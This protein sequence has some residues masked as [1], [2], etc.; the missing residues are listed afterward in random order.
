MRETKTKQVQQTRFRT[1][2][3]QM[4]CRPTIRVPVCFQY[5]L[6]ECIKQAIRPSTD[7]SGIN[8][9]RA[10]DQ[11]INRMQW[12]GTF[13]SRFMESKKDFPIKNV[14]ALYNRAHMLFEYEM[15]QFPRR[16]GRTLTKKM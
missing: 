14:V 3:I 15:K 13:T 11:V 16:W 9:S 10:E 12:E 5:E 1:K 6:H 2:L 4:Q 7:G 8:V